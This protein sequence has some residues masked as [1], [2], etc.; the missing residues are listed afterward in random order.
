MQRALVSRNGALR[1]APDHSRCD[2]DHDPIG[3]HMYRKTLVLAAVVFTATLSLGGSALPKAAASTTSA[4]EAYWR[5]PSGFAFETSGSAVHCKKPSWTETK[6]FMAC[7]LATPTLKIDLLSNTDMCAGSVGLTVT[8]EPQC[9]P[10][11]IVNGFT[12]RHVSGK[13]FCGKAHPAE[14]VAPNQ[15]ISL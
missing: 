1:A 5:C 6:P 13:D 8:A 4:A 12:K 15:L 3:G 2:N 14:V 11:D 10:T 9:Y 7:T